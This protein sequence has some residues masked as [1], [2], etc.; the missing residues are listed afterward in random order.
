MQNKDIFDNQGD[1]VSIVGYPSN[2]M[3]NQ[4]PN[5]FMNHQ[6]Y[7]NPMTKLPVQ[8][9]PMQNPYYNGY[10]PQPQPQY[11]QYYPNNP[12]NQQNRCN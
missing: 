10:Q 5:Y 3:Q 9:Q 7:M 6:G 2:P 4:S 8:G 1:S 11:N 12:Y